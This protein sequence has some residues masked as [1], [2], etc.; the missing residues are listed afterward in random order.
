[1]HLLRKRDAQLE[2]E[3]LLF[4]TDFSQGFAPFLFRDRLPRDLRRRCAQDSAMHAF[5]AA[6]NDA[7]AAVRSTGLCENAALFALSVQLL[8]TRVR[9]IACD[10]ALVASGVLLWQPPG[11]IPSADEVRP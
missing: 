7:F 5:F 10:A 4:S 8:A 1:V 9:G 11:G 6:W 3:A 2:R